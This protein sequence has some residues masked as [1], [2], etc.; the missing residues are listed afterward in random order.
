MSGSSAGLVLH[1]AA[2]CCLA[3]A[4]RGDEDDIDSKDKDNLSK[5]P[6]NKQQQERQ[7]LKKIKSCGVRKARKKQRNAIQC[8][9]DGC[10]REDCDQCRFC[11]DKPKNGGRGTIRR[12]CVERQCVKLA[13]P[14]PGCN[15]WYKLP[16]ELKT[17]VASAHFRSSLE[18]KIN[19]KAKEKCK[20]DNCKFINRDTVGENLYH[21]G[22]VHKLLKD[23]DADVSLI[24]HLL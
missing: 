9:C 15:S 6:E 3:A 7:I 1:W 24:L 18:K 22:F 16:Y 20:I 8:K 17:H 11:L 13:C 19:V 2:P 14:L 5:S 10:S 4:V 23:I 21:Y 12:R